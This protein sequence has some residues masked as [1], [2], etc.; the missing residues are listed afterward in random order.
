MYFRTRKVVRVMKLRD[1]F[2]VNN[3]DEGYT[4]KV[5]LKELTK[6]QKV[7]ITNFGF[8]ITH[9]CPNRCAHCAPESAPELGHTSISMEQAE[10]WAGDM[11]DLAAAGV[12]GINI[13]GGEPLLLPKVLKIL[14]EAATN[15]GIIFSV[16]TAAHWA[17]TYE[18]AVKVIEDHPSIKSWDISTDIWHLPYVSLERVKNAYQACL[19]LGREVEIR[20]AHPEPLAGEHLELFN[21]LL[22]FADPKHLCCQALRNLGRGQENFVQIGISS[23]SKVQ[24]SDE[25]RTK[26][27]K[28]I[29]RK[30][31]MLEE[32][33]SVWHAPCLSGGAVVKHDGTVAPCCVGFQEV[34]EDHDPM[35]LPVQLGSAS[36]RAENTRSLKEIFLDYI[37]DPKMLLLRALGIKEFVRWTIE[38][39]LEEFVPEPHELTDVCD[40]CDHLF[41]EPKVTAAINQKLEN[42]EIL[43]K[44]IALIADRLLG[45]PAGLQRFAPEYLRQEET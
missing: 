33:H 20:F 3:P 37:S 1:K 11:E 10:A 42:E 9:A 29:E 30:L 41:S 27:E 15:A 23:S 16:V 19:D 31:A 5:S 36:L 6:W 21:Q 32:N 26:K 12:R 14:G 17:R 38:A 18:N 45:E 44:K 13:T 40:M 35:A 7:S 25:Q 43:T 4:R 2:T 39:G 34:P 28:R 8:S 22:E 24:S